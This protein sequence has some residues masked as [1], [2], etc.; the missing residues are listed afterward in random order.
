MRGHD[1]YRLSDTEVLDSKTLGIFL[2]RHDAEV[3][4]RYKPIFDA[5]MTDYPIFHQ[6]SKPDWKPDNRIAVNF[7]K[8]IVDTMNGFFIGVPIKITCDD[9]NVMKYIELLDQYNDQDDNNAEL[10]KMC[11][12]YGK[13]YEMYFVDDKGNIGITYVSPLEAFIIYDDSVLERPRYFVRTYIDSDNVLHGSVSDSEKVR[14]FVQRGQII[15]EDEKLH[16]FDG[17]PATEYCENEERMGIYEPA[18]SMINAYNKAISEKAND[19]DSFAD[20]YMKILGAKVEEESMKEIRANRI[21][22]F[23]GNLNGEL[24]VDFLQKPNGDTTQENLINRLEKLIFQ[25]S[26]VAN[27]SDESFGASSGIA[28]KYKLQAM[29]NLAKTKERKFSS[30]MNRRYML[31]FSNPVSGMKKDDWIK[32]HYTFTQNYPANVLEESQ[33]AGNLSGIT[34][35]ETQLKILSVVNNV[36]EEVERIA[37]EKDTMGYETDYPIGRTVS[38]NDILGTAAAGTE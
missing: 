11:S 26:M 22:N 14:Y 2:E 36:N 1:I 31:I 7:A 35:Q 25:I 32:L 20:A 24:E 10:S 34:S 3:A 12:I 21:I 28:L 37:K 17:V 15:W 29:S 16:S 4:H 30:G 9:P 13:G 33:I 8:Y 38:G 18:L 27:I 19:V 23:D 6:K 5:Y